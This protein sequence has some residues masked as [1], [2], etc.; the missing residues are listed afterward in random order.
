MLDTSE[1]RKR[2]EKVDSGP[3]DYTY[4]GSSDYSIGNARDPQET[5]FGIL[6]QRDHDRAKPHLDFIA[7]AR[8]DIPA[9]LDEVERLRK[10][11]SRMNDYLLFT[12]QKVC[13]DSNVWTKA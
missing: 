2:L 3:W 13:F 8:Q 4:D 1:I 12:E 7:H 6:W 10:I 5:A 9:L 11:V